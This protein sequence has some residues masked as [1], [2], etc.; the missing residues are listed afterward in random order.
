MKAK[1]KPFTRMNATELAA[2]TRQFD[3]PFVID[4]GRPLSARER[5]RHLAAAIRGQVRD[6][7][8][9][10]VRDFPLRRIK[11]QRQHSDAIGVL[12]R[13]S[14][15]HQTT[16]QGGVTDY[17]D[18]LADL[19]DQYERTANLKVDTSQSSPAGVVR[20]LIENNALTVSGLAREI[21]ISQ[22]NLSE[23]LSGRRDF[24]KRAIAGLR[25]RFGVS[26]EI[27]F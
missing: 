8:R 25:D 24:S 12:A 20:H 19:I 21:G 5:R 16:R 23:M 1:S 11:N 6:P 18:V 14:L 7:Y 26:P 27:F 10:L 3:A 9:D 22:S 15:S 17:L 2:A 13:I 4:K